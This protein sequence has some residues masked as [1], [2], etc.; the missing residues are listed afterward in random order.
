MGMN[1]EPSSPGFAQLGRILWVALCP[2]L[3][4][5]T[6][7]H[8]YQNGTGW[9]TPAD[10]LFFAILTAMILGRWLEVLGGHPLT[11]TGEPATPE[12]FRRYVVITLAVGFTIWIL[13]N[14]IGNHG[15]R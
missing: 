12:D 4:A 2:A 7:I 14:A 10:Y 8:I 3:L 11:G 15:V 5:I 9:H 1:T 13:V 6:T